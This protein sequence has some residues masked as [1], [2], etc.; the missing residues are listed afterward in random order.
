L[1]ASW[2]VSTCG[3]AGVEPNGELIGGEDAEDGL[4]AVVAEAADLVAEDGVVAGDGGGEVDVGDLAGEGVLFEAHLGD[5]E[6]V[7]DVLGA[8]GEVDLAAG[9]EDELA[10]DDVVVAVGVGAVDAEG[11]A[12][13][14]RGEREFGVA[15]VGVCAGVAEV[16]DEL[17]AGDFD[18]HGGEVG[19]GVALGGPE[20]LRAEGE[21]AEEEGEGGE[22]EVFEEELVAGARRAMAEGKAEE[23]DEVGEGEESESDPEI[24]EEM[25]V[26]SGAVECGV[27]GEV[28]EAVRE[29]DGWRGRHRLIVEG[30][31]RVAAVSA[32]SRSFL[33]GYAQGQE[34]IS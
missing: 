4:H 29:R 28:P 30:S 18:L 23:E 21:A 15:E 33:F 26:E 22:R 16:P 6:A 10:G 13:G 3:F 25:A 14:S 1:W 17:H 12:F 5:G 27:G 24:E 8:E 31:W 9:G 20:L 11:V 2:M 34:Q 32:G 7:D 19:A